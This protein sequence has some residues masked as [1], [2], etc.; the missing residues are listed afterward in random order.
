MGQEAPERTELAVRETTLSTLATDLLSPQTILHFDFDGEVAKRTDSGKDLGTLQ[1][2]LARELVEIARTPG[3]DTWRTMT[4]LTMVT[5]Y[6][7]PF[8]YV[9]EA[10]KGGSPVTGIYGIFPY[11]LD[12]GQTFQDT[13]DK[14]LTRLSDPEYTPRRLPQSVIDAMPRATP[15]ESA[16]QV[17]RLLQVAGYQFPSEDLSGLK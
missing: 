2:Q 11:R 12:T 6:P 10:E 15:E 3:V 14:R 4:A 13:I 1:S 16:R 5:R 8:R 7:Q 9:E 17:R